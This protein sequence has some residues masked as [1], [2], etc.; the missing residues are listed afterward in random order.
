MLLMMVVLPLA[1]VFF[2]GMW[3]AWWLTAD[4]VSTNRSIGSVH[5][6]PPE[7]VRSAAQVPVQGQQLRIA[8]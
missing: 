7:W 6:A 3:V 4:V 2:V 8:R 1:G 5:T